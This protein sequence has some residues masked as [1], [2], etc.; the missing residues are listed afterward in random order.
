MLRAG[1]RSKTM[2][3]LSEVLGRSCA[4]TDPGQ[5]GTWL[6][7]AA[8]SN[9][10]AVV[11]HQTFDLASFAIILLFCFRPGM[12]TPFAVRKYWIVIVLSGKHYICGNGS[13]V[14]N[15]R[16]AGSV[17]GLTGLGSAS[18]VLAFATF[19]QFVARPTAAFIF[20]A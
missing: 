12:F 20:N 7:N 15:S 10:A 3:R 18:R 14:K 9:M 17:A 1:A 6:D 11:L 2:G 16:L 4:A 13:Q 5:L 19:N 8:I